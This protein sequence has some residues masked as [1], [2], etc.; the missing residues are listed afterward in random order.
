MSCFPKTVFFILET[1]GIKYVMTLCLFIFNLFMC[2]V[3]L[4]PLTQFGRNHIG[5]NCSAS[6]KPS[7]A[8][9]Y[10]LTPCLTFFLPLRLQESNKICD[11]S[12]SLSR[13]LWHNLT[14]KNHRVL[15]NTFNI[16][17][18]TRSVFWHI[19]LLCLRTKRPRDEGHIHSFMKQGKG[20]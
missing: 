10:M 17:E 15:F 16:M 3:F 2:L 12:V 7:R 4:I 1:A 13:Y 6:W 9:P 20:E 11:A 5:F 14:W 18:T 8:F 19:S